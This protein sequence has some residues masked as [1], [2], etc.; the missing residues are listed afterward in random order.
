[1]N[2]A[3]EKNDGT[4]LVG[5]LWGRRDGGGFASAHPSLS[6]R[7][8]CTPWLGVDQPVPVRA[9]FG[10]ALPLCTHLLALVSLGAPLPLHPVRPWGEGHATAYRRAVLWYRCGWDNSD[11]VDLVAGLRQRQTVPTPQY[12]EGRGSSPGL[13]HRNRTSVCSIRHTVAPA[14]YA[15]GHTEL[16]HEVCGPIISSGRT[17]RSNSSPLSS[18]SATAASRKVV[19]SAWAFL[20]ILAALS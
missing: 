8:C 1:L 7:H 19:P 13:L 16:A 12:P 3:D 18:C 17:R 10:Q 4:L 2:R 6:P 5:A 9:P 11:V 20:A 14:W 15:L